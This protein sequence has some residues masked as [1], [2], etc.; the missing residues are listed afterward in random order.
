MIPIFTPWP[1]VREPGA[2]ERIRADLLR[3]R[4]ELR[5]VAA[6]GEDLAHAVELA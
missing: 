3:G 4:V 6:G 5:A 2:P 1:A